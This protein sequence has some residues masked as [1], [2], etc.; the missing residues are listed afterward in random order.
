MLTVEKMG[1]IS[2]EFCLVSWSNSGR[3]LQSWLLAP[4]VGRERDQLTQLLTLRTLTFS[5]LSCIEIFFKK[6][7]VL[8]IDHEFTTFFN[9]PR[10]KH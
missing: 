10:I 3:T 6:N 8:G 1:E 7:L 2:L 9:P 5:L 4:F